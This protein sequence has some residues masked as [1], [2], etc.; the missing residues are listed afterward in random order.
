MSCCV[1]VL[2][3]ALLGACEQQDNRVSRIAQMDGQSGPASPARIAELEELLEEYAELAAEQVQTLSRSADTLKLLSQAYLQQRMF[4]PALDSLERALVIEPE[5][6]TL[7]QL[8]GASAG[9]V[10]KAQSRAAERQRYFDMAEFHY[11]RAIEIEP[12]FIDARYGLAVLYAFELNEPA[13]ALPH[14]EAILARNELHVPS[15]FVL[16][17][18]NVQLGNIDAA[19]DAYDTIIE[20]AAEDEDRERARRNRQLLVGSS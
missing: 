1:L 14:L 4:G 15:L 9:F 6:Q 8:A 16:A 11:Q 5:N 20:R 18:A 19:I 10:A 2:L 7:H 3:G 13:N 17:R 12:D